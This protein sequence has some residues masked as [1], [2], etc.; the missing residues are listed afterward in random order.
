MAIRTHPSPLFFVSV[1]SKWV[2]FTVSCV[3]ATL[4]G[5]LVNVDSREFT[6]K[7]NSGPSAASCA[8]FTRRSTAGLAVVRDKGEEA[9]T[10]CAAQHF[11]AVC[12][13]GF[14]GDQGAVRRRVAPHHHLKIKTRQRGCRAKLLPKMP[15]TSIAEMNQSSRGEC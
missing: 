12:N 8:T 10:L 5:D 7:H 13:P 9:S 15:E 6:G 14:T 3:D 2:R 4:A 11:L 1:D